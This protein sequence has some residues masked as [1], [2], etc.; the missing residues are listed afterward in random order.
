MIKKD[1]NDVYNIKIVSL[2]WDNIDI[3]LVDSQ[4]KVF[5]KFGFHIEQQNI[6]N[7]DHGVWMTDI[8][9]NT[10]ENDVVIIVDIDC[11]PLNENAVKKAIVSARNGHIYG[12]AQ[13]ANHIDYNYIYAAPMFLA[14]TGKTWRGVGRPTLLANTE[15]DVGGKLTLVAKNAGYS[16]DLVYPTDYA[17]PKWLLGDTH[18][19]GLFTI[20]N[21]DY[22]HIFESRNKY[23]IECFI[24]IANEIISKEGFID[25]RKYI[26]KASS[27]SH[28]TFLKNYIDKKNIIGKIKRELK[29]FKKRRLRL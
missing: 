9:D 29:R 25:Y 16:V 28:K 27:E 19:Y 2:Y 3:R 10:P 21:N 26:I 11:I 8:L 24:D 13:S 4:R 17:V 20:Y 1:I 12:C 23:L 22:L 14:L 15:F 7:M 5:E 6:H 18:V